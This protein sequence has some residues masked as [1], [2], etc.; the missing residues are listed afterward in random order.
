MT[1]VCN[2]LIFKS[3]DFQKNICKWPIKKQIEGTSSDKTSDKILV[4][5]VSLNKSFQATGLLTTAV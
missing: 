3:F 5:E 1:H 2:G 4:T